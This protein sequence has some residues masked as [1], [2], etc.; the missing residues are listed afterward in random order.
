MRAPLHRRRHPAICPPSDPTGTALVTLPPLPTVSGP[1]TAAAARLVMIRGPWQGP[2]TALGDHGPM[3]GA[4]GHFHGAPPSTVP[5][6]GCGDPVDRG[7][8]GGCFG[9]VDRGQCQ[10]GVAS[11]SPSGAV[12]LVPVSHTWNGTEVVVATGPSSPTVANI[13]ANPKVRLALGETRDV[14]MIDAV[15]VSAVP[16]LMPRRHWP[17]GMPP[18]PGGTRTDEGDYVYL[19]LGCER[20]QVSG[21]GEEL[22]G[23]TVMRNGAWVV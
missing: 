4:S 5:N 8:Q 22:A 6:F 21:E 3:T 23:R 16:L 10:C 2:D 1:S 17:M 12:H 19:V 13:T 18:R 11:A 7:A 14:V 15:L 9:Q 20:I